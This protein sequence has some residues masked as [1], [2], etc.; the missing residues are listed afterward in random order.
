MLADERAKHQSPPRKMIDPNVPNKELID[1][2]LA[3]KK[4]RIEREAY[5]KE[6]ARRRLE[7]DDEDSDD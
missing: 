1:K 6:L 4:R 2:M 7:E 5:M 3:E